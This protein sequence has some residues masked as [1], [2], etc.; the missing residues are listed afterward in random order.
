MAGRRRLELMRDYFSDSPGIYRVSKSAN[1]KGIR[2][3]SAA[4]ECDR[5]GST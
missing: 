1:L 2:L 4:R 3:T 5:L